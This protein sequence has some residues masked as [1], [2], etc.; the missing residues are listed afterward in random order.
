MKKFISLVL[1]IITVCM[2]TIGTNAVSMESIIQPRWDDASTVD[3]DLSFN[4][5][6]QNANVYAKITGRSGTTQISGTLT[7]YE[8]SGNNLT[9]LTS[10]P[11]S[12]TQYISFSNSDYV[13]TSGVTYTLKLSG[14]VYRNGNSEIVSDSD[15][16]VCP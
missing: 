7:L 1:L 16:Y 9:Y 4:S 15:C 11:L 13:C 14:T 12:G 2:L 5:G 6:S 10:W 3:C 8:G